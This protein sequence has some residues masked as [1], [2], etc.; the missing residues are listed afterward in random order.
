MATSENKAVIETDVVIFPFGDTTDSDHLPIS[1]P[2][3]DSRAANEDDREPEK[4]KHKVS[5]I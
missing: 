4:R 2:K 3:P 5:G 1:D